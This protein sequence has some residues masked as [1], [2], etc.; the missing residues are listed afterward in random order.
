MDGSIRRSLARYIASY[1]AAREGYST[2][3]PPEVAELKQACDIVLV[4][5]NWSSLQVLCIVDG[6]TRRGARFRMRPE[7]V[8]EIAKACLK[9]CGSMN[10][11]KMPALVE[12]VEISDEPMLTEDEDRLRRFRRSSLFSKG[13]VSACRVDARTWEVWRNCGR[14][15][16]TTVERILQA[17]VASEAELRT[18]MSSRPPSTSPSFPL[19]TACVIAMLA[20][21]FMLERSVSGG[22]EP[23]VV[24]LTALGGLSSK[25]VAAGEWWRAMSATI[26]HAGVS[27]MVGN[28]IGLYVA[29]RILENMVGRTWF[30][31]TY[32]LAGGCGS[33]AS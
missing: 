27:H 14:L 19:M 9:Y 16:R 33:L 15:G 1:C 28:A 24:T 2:R 26:L 22:T 12:I 13:H 17:P 25:L 10:F 29:G 7:Q 5:L 32:L 31:A 20:G 4:R 30:V 23:T 6:Q 11:S 3:L 18:E 8:Q 21:I